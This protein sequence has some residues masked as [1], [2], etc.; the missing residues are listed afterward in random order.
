MAKTLSGGERDGRFQMIQ[1]V[2][3][4]YC[5][6]MRV[7]RVVLFATVLL[8]CREAAGQ[9]TAQE[10]LENQPAEEVFKNIQVLKGISA[11]N[12]QGAMSF[13]ASSLN[14]DCDYCH[15]GE[16]FSKDVTKQKL[17]AREMIRMVRQINQEAFMGENR[18]NCFTCHQG[19]AVPIALAPLGP[20]PPRPPKA[21]AEDAEKPVGSLFPSVEEVL[22]HYVQALGG[23]AALDG[24]KS[25]I[26][27]TTP[28]NHDDPESKTVLYQKTQGK[29]LLSRESP[30]Y[31]L[32]V[33]YNGKRAWAQDSEKSYWGILN[34]PQ[35]NSIM[36]DSEI[37]PG[38]RIKSQY[39]N[40]KVES[41][42]KIG[43][44]DT[45]V[46]VGT[47]PEGTS[48]EFFFDVQTGL[49]LRRHIVEQTIFGGFQI[50][51]D[52]EDYREIRGVKTPFVV[53][54]SSPGGA[55]GTK[56]STK[57][58]EIRDNVPI[59]DEKFDGPPSTSH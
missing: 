38:N 5:G 48:E 51:A 10:P 17:R 28:L 29:V 41:K 16:D 20:A 44:H 7:M 1:Q 37:Y 21:G 14:V 40:V 13:I 36:R 43:D 4:L 24:V 18:V 39:A 42:E 46:V 33:G 22:D 31:S 6:P 26:I 49:L 12:L 2:P 45:Y 54:W 58:L 27:R 11:A 52:F 8:F 47:S 19:H 50:Q 35:R 30:S 55:W 32:W 34:T 23:Q 56:V 53:R 15:R 25:R 59:E 9:T 57:I 3:R